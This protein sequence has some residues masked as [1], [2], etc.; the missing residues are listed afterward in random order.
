MRHVATEL[1]LARIG[2][3][4]LG[5]LPPTGGP[6]VG[7]EPG[8]QP[9]RIV[10]AA[11]AHQRAD[12]AEFVGRVVLPRL[13]ALDARIGLGHVAVE[14]AAQQRGG[15]LVVGLSRVQRHRRGRG[16]EV[17]PVGG[18]G[19]V[20]ELEMRSGRGDGGHQVGLELVAR[21]RPASGLRHV[22]QR[23]RNLNRILV[24][25]QRPEVVPVRIGRLVAVTLVADRRRHQAFEPGV[26]IRLAFAQPQ[27]LHPR[28]DLLHLGPMALQ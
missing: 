6:L 13:R 10:H 15:Q 14:G 24:A 2:Q 7:E 25:A 27:R 19:D 3:H 17:A 11:Q 26:R 1:H 4:D 8:Q 28:N 18:A 23:L 21:R 9:V 5:P 22:T 20:V 16:V 12:V